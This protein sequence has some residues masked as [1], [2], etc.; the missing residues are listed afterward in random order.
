M[1]TILI[2][3]NETNGITILSERSPVA[4]L[5]FLG[6]SFLGYW[7]EHLASRGAKEVR[8]VTSDDPDYIRESVGNGARWGVSLEI[9]HEVRE[10]SAAE[11]RKRYRPAYETDWLPEDV[12]EADHLPG[13]PE[14]KIYSSYAN[15]FKGLSLWMPFVAQSKR[16][17][18]KE[19]QP[20]VWAGRKR[21][22]ASSVTFKGPC[23]IG[24]NVRIGK[25]SVVGPFAFIEDNS[26]IDQ[27]VEICNSW[28]GPD[29]FLGALT[30]VHESL[31]W[32]SLLINWKSGSHI[33]VPDSFLMSSLTKDRWSAAKARASE[34][35]AES[36]STSP[37]SRPIEAVISLAQKLQS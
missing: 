5:P 37:L 12:I 17:G 6:E 19:I 15:W 8:L 9:F 32:G 34:K 22:I 24:D 7:L 23:Y 29:T 1:K 13:M 14:H 21:K 35:A 2:C 16:I 30:R 4:N 11:A 25:D 28:I 27:S 18:L 31:G 26:V 20:G 3:P 36:T 33:V 10:L